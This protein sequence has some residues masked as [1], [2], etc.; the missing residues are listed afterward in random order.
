MGIG[1]DLADI[2]PFRQRPFA[3]NPGFYRLTFTEAEQE[4]CLSRPDPAPHW[5][6]RFAA[7]EAAVKALSALVVAVPQVEVTRDPS[8]APGLRL[9]S[10]RGEALPALPPLRLWVSLSHGAD[11]AVAFVVVTVEG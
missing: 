9:V 8:G 6:A 1:T 7:K 11:I 2:A 10:R 3:D 5:A 4:Y